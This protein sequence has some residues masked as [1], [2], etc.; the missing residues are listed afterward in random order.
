M[1]EGE[2]WKRRTV[3]QFLLKKK[4]SSFKPRG[5]ARE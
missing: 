5:G 4:L 2:W 3:L 1:Q